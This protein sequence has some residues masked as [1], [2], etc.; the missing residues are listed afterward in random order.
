MKLYLGHY[1]VPFPSSEYGG[2]WAVIASDEQE[3]VE[4]LRKNAGDYYEEY[5]DRIQGEVESAQ[6][7]DLDPNSSHAP[8][9]VDTFFS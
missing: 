3:C 2:T 9:I 6:V 7:F 5:H 8:R 1:W 4:L